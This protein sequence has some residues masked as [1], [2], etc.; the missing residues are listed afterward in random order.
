MI[1]KYINDIYECCYVWIQIIVRSRTVR[2]QS[3]EI[4]CKVNL[5]SL[6][7]PTEL[8]NELYSSMAASLG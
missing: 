6:G 1:I 3:Y 8:Y 4:R 2:S 7:L 5:V